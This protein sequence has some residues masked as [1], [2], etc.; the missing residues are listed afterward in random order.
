MIDFLESLWQLCLIIGSL[1]GFCEF[2]NDFRKW[3]VNRKN[4]KD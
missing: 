3:I 1:R 2:V 4:K